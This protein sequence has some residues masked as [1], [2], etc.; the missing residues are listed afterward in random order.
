MEFIE[1]LDPPRDAPAEI[2]QSFQRIYD[3]YFNDTTVRDVSS[4][5]K[6]SG[7]G[8]GFPHDRI[9]LRDFIACHWARWLKLNVTLPEPGYDTGSMESVPHS[10]RTER[11]RVRRTPRRGVG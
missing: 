5:D 7:P 9:E 11:Q 1:Q 6:F 8:A 4:S 2:L 10:R 3:R